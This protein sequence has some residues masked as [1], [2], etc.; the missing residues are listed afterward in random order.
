MVGERVMIVGASRG[1][2]LQLAAAYAAGGAQVHATSHVR[3]DELRELA[4]RHSGRVVLHSLD[5]RSVSG[6]ARLAASLG[7]EALNLLIHVAG[8]GK[9]STSVQLDVNARAPFAVVD[10]LVPVLL[11]SRAESGGGGRRAPMA[12][13]ITSDIGVPR[14]CVGKCSGGSDPWKCTQSVPQHGDASSL[15]T[16]DSCGYVRSKLAANYVFRCVAAP[17]WRARGVQAVVMQPGW[18]TTDMT[19]W[20]INNQT[21][22]ANESA[23]A[24][25]ATLAA[26]PEDSQ[27]VL[28]DYR[29]YAWSWETGKLEDCAVAAPVRHYDDNPAT[30]RKLRIRPWTTPKPGTYPPKWSSCPSAPP[31]HGASVDSAAVAV[32]QPNISA[33]QA[34]DPLRRGCPRVLRHLNHSLSAAETACG[35]RDDPR[36]CGF[37]VPLDRES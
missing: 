15:A 28:L 25:R 33:P 7:D 5:V 20:T 17:D 11:R 34:S 26:L 14:K 12:A 37:L 29:G 6:V 1:I 22:R 35:P 9:G 19:G 4:E 21:I 8:V 31:R 30:L 2:G 27:K 36:R 13:I 24:I 23:A 18:V 10:A 16:S 32:S 3:T